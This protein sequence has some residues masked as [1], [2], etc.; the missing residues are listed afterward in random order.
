[1]SPWH[2]GTLGSSLT[3]V[4]L[5]RPERMN[6]HFFL[7]GQAGKA[8]GLRLSAVGSLPLPARGIWPLS[9]WGGGTQ[10]RRGPWRAP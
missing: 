1:M 5:H 7:K 3:W 9:N 6:R 10:V 8:A 2:W 4:L